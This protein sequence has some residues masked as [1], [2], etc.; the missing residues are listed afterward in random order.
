MQQKIFNFL[1]KFR[2][3]TSAASYMPEIDG[4]RF[5]A[6]FW[7]VCWM[8][9]SN[10]VNIKF[11][12]NQ[13]FSS[14]IANVF[15]EGGYGV[16]FFYMIS[17][18]ILALPFAKH[19]LL[20]TKKVSLK[21]YYIRRVTR[22]EPPYLA[23]LFIAFLGLVLINKQSIRELLPHLGASAIYC[24][25]LIYNTKSTILGVAWSLE[26]EVRFYLMAP[27]LAYLFKINNRGLRYLVFIILILFFSYT[28]FSVYGEKLPL[29]ITSL[30]WFLSGMLLCD[31]YVNK[32]SLPGKS[33]YWSISGVLIF[34]FSPFLLSYNVFIP[35]L[36]KVVL[37]SLLFYIGITT[38]QMKQILSTQWIT[39]IGGMCYSIYLLQ[40]IIMSGFY[41]FLAKI[42][43]GNPW[44]GFFVYG[45]I[46]VLVI[47]LLSAIFY[48]LIEQPCM[49][50]DWYK[51]I[52]YR[53]NRI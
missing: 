27:F 34:L 3:I 49:R 51:W 40:F 16:A 25:D 14:Y 53:K 10:F 20:G 17:G 42:N 1:E 26:V 35:F 22:L 48:R 21:D 23:A 4:L 31:M 19:Y 30:G 2:R 47:V 13:L 41:P 32:I 44:L 11:F 28:G 8:H 43:I 33:L 36:I 37:L 7:V 15:I 6:I 50:R 45:G 18:F 5:I 24:H 9:T 52:L 46:I 12:N 38:K 29:I 39:I